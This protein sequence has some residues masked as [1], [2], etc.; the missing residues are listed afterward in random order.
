M[1][2]VAAV[3]VGERFSLAWKHPHRIEA[4]IVE[5]GPDRVLVE[6]VHRCPPTCYVLQMRATLPI[7]G[8]MAFRY[9]DFDKLF[10]P[11]NTQAIALPA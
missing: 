10:Q 4:T 1:R 5:L 3:N 2:V 7:E 8:R 11:M 9:E 6:S